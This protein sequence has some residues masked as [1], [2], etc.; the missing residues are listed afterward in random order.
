MHEQITSNKDEQLAIAEKLFA[1]AFDG[2][3]DPRSLEYKRGVMA[4]LI[5]RFADIE[6]SKNNPYKL[7]TVESDAFFAGCEEGHHIWRGYAKS[8]DKAEEGVR[9]G[10]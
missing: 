4:A 9:V 5:Y 3:R 10:L 8:P 6:I 2:P 7:G 1:E